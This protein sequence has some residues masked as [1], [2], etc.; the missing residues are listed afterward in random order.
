[1]TIS[2]ED[3]AVTAWVRHRAASSFHPLPVLVDAVRLYLPEADFDWYP[4]IAESILANRQ[5]MDN[6]WRIDD[7][8]HAEFH[9][10]D[11]VCLA[12]VAFHKAPPEYKS[13]FN[14]WYVRLQK[15]RLRRMAEAGL[16]EPTP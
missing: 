9:A 15:T 2:E 8:K 1:M 5:G 7:F 13:R 11:P 3:Q 12:L 4:I 6:S 10:K 16:L 14:N